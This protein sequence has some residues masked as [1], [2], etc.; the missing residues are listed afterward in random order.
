MKSLSHLDS[1][2]RAKMVDVSEKEETFREAVARGRVLLG[3]EAFEA[4]V[5]GGL[6]KGDLFTVAKIAGIMAAKKVYELIPLCHPLPVTHVDIDFQL[7][8]QQFAV[9]IEATVRTK[10]ATGVEMEALCA[11]SLAALTIYDMCKAVSHAI[12]IEDIRLARKS[13]GRSGTIIL[14]K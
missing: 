8:E 5:T 7:D 13:G 2:G 6:K 11:C 9:E 14:E 10:A 3:K 12:R 1:S 4:A